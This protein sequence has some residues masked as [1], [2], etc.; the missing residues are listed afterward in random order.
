MKVLDTM[1]KLIARWGMLYLPSSSGRCR[2]CGV[3][4]ADGKPLVEGESDVLIC[5]N[6]VM[7]AQRGLHERSLTDA[8]SHDDADA[9]PYLPPSNA[10]TCL[11]CGTDDG[12][13]RIHTFRSGDII[14][15]QCVG[16]SIAL[17]DAK[18]ASGS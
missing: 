3:S 6:C 18:E 16:I 11:F 12:N 8:G 5:R 15:E 4:Y 10:I 7:A 9:N 1:L 14:C 2:F 13:C 17:M